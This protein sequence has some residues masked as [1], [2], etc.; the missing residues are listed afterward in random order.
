MGVL[1]DVSLKFSECALNF[2]DVG[3]SQ[4]IERQL[5]ILVFLA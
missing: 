2:S 3:R 4:K 5:E 1:C